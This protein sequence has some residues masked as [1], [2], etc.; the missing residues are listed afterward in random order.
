M[1]PRA[2]QYHPDLVTVTVGGSLIQGYADGEFVTVEPMS[3]AV[4]EEVGTDGEV[5]ISR[6]ADRRMKVT[7]KLIGTSLSN[8][9][10]SSIVNAQLNAPGAMPTVNVQV[11]DVLG[12]SIASGAESWISKWP[13][14]SYDRT[15]KT[16]EW[17]IHVASGDREELGN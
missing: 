5:A 8:A 11:E 16:L 10:L 6:S 14:K 7:I 9:V 12:G 4:L 2:A 1:P 15:A 3:D 13:Q 17:E